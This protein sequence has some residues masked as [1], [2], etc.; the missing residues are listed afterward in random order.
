MCAYFHFPL[1]YVFP[2][3]SA[4]PRFSQCHPCVRGLGAAITPELSELGAPALLGIHRTPGIQLLQFPFL[5]KISTK[6]PNHPFPLAVGVQQMRASVGVGMKR[7]FLS[8]LSGC[9]CGCSPVDSTGCFS[10]AIVA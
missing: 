8:R 5:Y 9:F 10:H 6:L 3:L 2:F 7:R 4:T 1:N